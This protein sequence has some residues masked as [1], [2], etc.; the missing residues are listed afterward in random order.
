M[1]VDVCWLRLAAAA[2]GACARVLG[3]NYMKEAKR[4]ASRAKLLVSSASLIWELPDV[5]IRVHVIYRKI[6]YYTLEFKEL[7][8]RPPA[9]LA[10]SHRLLG[11]SPRAPFSAV[12]A[13]DKGEL[14]GSDTSWPSSKFLAPPYA[15]S[16]VWQSPFYTRKPKSRKHV[17][18]RV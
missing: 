6:P 4:P 16:A 11:T 10:N 2:C 5:K 9:T 17:L 15:T 14:G 7:N 3:I 8:T 18:F 13:L 12:V 1:D